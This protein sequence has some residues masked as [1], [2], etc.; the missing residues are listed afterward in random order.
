MI[1]IL[2][3]ISYILSFV[4]RFL[5]YKYPSSSSLVPP[6]CASINDGCVELTDAVG[7]TPDSAGCVKLTDSVGATPETV[8]CVELETVRVSQGRTIVEA[9]LTEV[10]CGLVA[11]FQ[12]HYN[13]CN[14]LYCNTNNN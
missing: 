11:K 7:A 14:N 6:L 2:L 13:K 9:R 5:T 12:K 10:D 1:I 3:S 4:A 8:G